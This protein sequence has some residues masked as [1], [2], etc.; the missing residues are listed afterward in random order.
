M[1]TFGHAS[2][3]FSDRW[4]VSGTLEALNDMLLLGLTTAFLYATMR[5]VHAAALGT[6]ANQ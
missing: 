4:Q 2:L 1:T 5:S 3:Q 6:P